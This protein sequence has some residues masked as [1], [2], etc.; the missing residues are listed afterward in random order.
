MRVDKRAHIILKGISGLLLVA[1][2]YMYSCSVLC[3]VNTS[4]CCKCCVDDDGCH[5]SACS[6]NEKKDNNC[7]ATHLSFFNA[8]G[9]YHFQGNNNVKIPSVIASLVYPSASI[10][11]F[12]VNTQELVYNSHSPPPKNDIKI[13][14]CSLQV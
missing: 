5:E 2:V 14:L 3:V 11:L 10:Q 8:L 12:L 6:K 7:Q 9:Q 1:V 4:D 13:R